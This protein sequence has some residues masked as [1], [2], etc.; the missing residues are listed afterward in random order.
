MTLTLA[1]GLGRREPQ[2]GPGQ[3]EVGLEFGGLGQAGDVDRARP[4]L[5]LRLD[6]ALRPADQDLGGD[7]LDLSILEPALTLPTMTGGISIMTS[8]FFELEMDLVGEDADDLGVGRG[9]DHVGVQR[10]VFLVDGRPLQVEDGLDVGRG[11]IR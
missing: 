5:V 8:C 2:L 6:L 9:D 7:E 3:N 10:V 4:D 11:E 1:L